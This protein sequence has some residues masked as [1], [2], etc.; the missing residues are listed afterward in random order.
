[1]TRTLFLIL[2]LP[3]ILAGSSIAEETTLRTSDPT[4]P[5]EE[6]LLRETKATIDRAVNWLAARQKE[7]GSWSDAQFPALT[8]LPLWALSVSGWDDAKARKQAVGFIVSRVHEDGSIFSDPSEVRKGGGL[9]NYNTAIS[10][11]ALHKTGDPSLVP[12]VQKARAYI[13]DSQHLGGDIYYG[14]MGYD[15]STQR[16]YTDLSNSYIAFEAMK[17][18][19]AVEDL[20]PKGAKRSNL[21]WKAATAFL[22][23]VQNN[24]DVNQLPWVADD[25]DNVGGFVYHPENTRAGTFT[26]ATGIVQFRSFGSMTY[27]GMLSYI[28]ADVDR[29]DPR[30]KSAFDWARRHWTLDENPGTGQ[31]GLFYYMNVLSKG[32]AAYGQDLVRPEEGAPFVWRTE[33]LKKLISM[34]KIDENGHGYWV[35]EAGRYWENNPELVTAYA[36]IALDYALHE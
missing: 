31:E 5:P 11:I 15:P 34:Q 22:Q 14:G 29:D 13:A 10:M 2:I 30:V 7:D 1:M 3:A 21:D 19:E 17:L 28:Y 25:A 23:K 32:M 18:T 26:N 20:K 27:A 33:L 4:W 16:P 35:N 8:G 36:L 6:S 9:P 12:V 24:P